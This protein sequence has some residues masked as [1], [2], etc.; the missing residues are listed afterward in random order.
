MTR[1]SEQYKF[2]EYQTHIEETLWD[3]NIII[4]EGFY[5]ELYGN[6]DGKYDTESSEGSS[7]FVYIDQPI[8]YGRLLDVFS[9]LG[10]VKDDTLTIRIIGEDE[11]QERGFCNPLSTLL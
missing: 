5:L 4:D 11:T 2:N 9:D 7:H 3:A 1:L 6:P 8:T 10:S